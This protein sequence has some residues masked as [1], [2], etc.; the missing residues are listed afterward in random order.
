VMTDGTPIQG[1][2]ARLVQQALP[3]RYG[4]EA[5]V[6]PP[7]LLGRTL[8]DGAALS[9]GA[10]PAFAVRGPIVFQYDLPTDVSFARL[11]RLSVHLTYGTTGRGAGV[12]VRLALFR[13][14]DRT[15]VDV[16]AGTTGVADVTFGAQFVDGGAIRL[17]VEPTGPEALVHQL[18]LSLEGSR[19]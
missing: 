8:V 19:V 7:G 3:I 6:V 18:D 5:L 12:P 15:W 16:P 14:T 10:Q 13:W 4:D 9:R 1:R 2:A 11:D 17:R